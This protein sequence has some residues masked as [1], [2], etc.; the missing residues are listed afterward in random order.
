MSP[1]TVTIIDV[2]SGQA[3]ATLPAPHGTHEVVI[4]SDGRTAVVT[5]YGTGPAPGSTLTVIDVP[6]RR[7]VRTIRLGEYRRPDA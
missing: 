1:S 3:L 4:S 7:V 5:D 2:A 6:G